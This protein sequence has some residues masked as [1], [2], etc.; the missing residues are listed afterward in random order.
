MSTAK[1]FSSPW[2]TLGFFLLILITLIW[3]LPFLTALLTS[4]RTN[5]D[6]L[7]QGFIAIPKEWTLQNFVTAWNRGGLHKYLPNSFIITIP[8]LFATL[9]L[10]SLSAYAL[11]RFK[12]PGNRLLFFLYVGGTM[13]PFQVLLLPVFRLTDA[14]GLYD[15]HLGLILF[16]TAFQ[17]GFCTFL[18]RNYMRTVPGEIL[19]AARIDGCGEFRIWAQI[20]MPLTLPALAALATLE[21]T[22]IFNDYLWAIVLLRT[23]ALKPVTAGLA[24]LQGQY[25]TDWTVIVAG[26]LIATVPTVLLFIFL[27][28]YFI[29]GLTLGATK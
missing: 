18:L 9:L 23:D 25:V 11:A 6:I 19:E 29:E 5:D 8:A 24:T 17:L 7:T 1:F 14:L 28:R 12:F 27:Q 20:M 15:T 4:V 10:S 22:W 2:R 26:A 3:L 13:L 21:F 16:H